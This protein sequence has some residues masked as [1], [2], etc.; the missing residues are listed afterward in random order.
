[1]RR[2]PLLALLLCSACTIHEPVSHRDADDVWHTSASLWGT[3][4]GSVRPSE[5]WRDRAYAGRELPDPTE[6]A[7]PDLPVD[8]LPRLRRLMTEEELVDL[9]GPPDRKF[10]ET[11]DI[12]TEERDWNACVYRW[13]YQE[14]RLTPVELTRDLDVRLAL[15]P[16]GR[17]L[18][19]R[20][21]V[22]GP[23]W[24]VVSWALF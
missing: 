17:P 10:V 6:I 16:K 21:E 14:S 13:K 19:E 3:G 4:S 20:P 18:P 23:T 11:V 2:I 24:V 5:G 15:V 8:A 1:M 7:W 22:V 12:D 9:L